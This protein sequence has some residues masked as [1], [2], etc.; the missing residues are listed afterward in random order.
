MTFGVTTR[1]AQIFMV[2][3]KCHKC[4]NVDTIIA[5]D[6]PGPHRAD[7]QGQVEAVLPQL[8]ERVQI[9]SQQ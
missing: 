4:G 1:V 2:G 9:S 7:Q 8:G 6:G 3:H 5:G